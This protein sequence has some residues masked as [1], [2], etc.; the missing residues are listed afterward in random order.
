MIE[1]IHTCNYECQ[2]PDCI[3]SQRDSLVNRLDQLVIAPWVI[4]TSADVRK[5]WQSENG[6]EDCVLYKID[7]FEKA[8]LFFQAEFI[9]KQKK[10]II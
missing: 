5:M 1:H 6:L 2:R 8:A 4:F 7:D 3:K 9:N 10:Q